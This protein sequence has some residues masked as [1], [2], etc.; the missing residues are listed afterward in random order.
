M[1]PATLVAIAAFITLVR[2]V[3]QHTPENGPDNHPLPEQNPPAWIVA[4]DRQR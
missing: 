4:L 2:A 1:K 3:A